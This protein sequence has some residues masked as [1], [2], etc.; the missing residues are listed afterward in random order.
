MTA[1]KLF[2][3]TW[4]FEPPVVIGCLGLWLIY[5]IAV[6]FKLNLKTLS[7]T[8]GLL[9]IFLALVSPI[10]ELGEDYLFSVHM[11]QHEILGFLAPPLLVAGIPESFILAALRYPL[12]KH[13]ERLFSY[14]VLTLI[15]GLGTLALWHLPVSL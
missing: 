1:W 4:N 13:F 15:L 7:F 10:D 5:I 11:L 9:L 3:T 6:R 8:F 2:L 12:L 14:P